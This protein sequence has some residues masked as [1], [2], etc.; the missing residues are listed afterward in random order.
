MSNALIKTTRKLVWYLARTPLI[1]V[2]KWI[3]RL[4]HLGLVASRK[5]LLSQLSISSLQKSKASFL[6]ANGWVE[7]SDLVDQQL[8]DR[9]AMRSDEKLRQIAENGAEV[10]QESAHKSFWVRLLDEEKVNGK[11]P[12]DN[13]YVQFALQDQLIGFLAAY[14]GNLPQLDDVL[15]TY[16]RPTGNKLSYSQLWHRDYD[17]T[18][19]VKVFAY[20]TDVKDREDGPFTLMQNNRRAASDVIVKSRYSDSSFEARY[21]NAE[22]KEFIAPKLTVFAVDTS[23]CYH[24]GSRVMAGR[25]RLLYTATFVD[26][27]RIYPEPPPRFEAPSTPLGDVVQNVLFPFQQITVRK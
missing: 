1:H 19:V 18:R 14:F 8:L 7:L 23:R 10:K 17:D 9:I 3:R 22:I 26:C 21:P 24:M 20:L 13:P 16:S 2:W 4:Q 25:S 12:V 27:P 15:L 11:Y 5:R 6:N